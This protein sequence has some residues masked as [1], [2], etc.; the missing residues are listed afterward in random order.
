MCC[1][2][3]SGLVHKSTDLKSGNSNHITQSSLKGLASSN[4]TQGGTFST[5]VLEMC[6]HLYYSMFPF[7]DATVKKMSSNITKCTWVEAKRNSSWKTLVRPKFD[8]FLLPT[9]EAGLSHVSQVHTHPCPLL[10]AHGS[11]SSRNATL[12]DM[13]DYIKYEM[14][15]L[16]WWLNFFTLTFAW[17]DKTN[18]QHPP[19]LNIPAQKKTNQL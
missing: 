16:Y 15:S 2:G 18:F 19:N 10:F 1:Q 3:W 13:R 5:Q 11:F 8:Y 14:K 17:L 9:T 4:I 7:S 12:R 6:N